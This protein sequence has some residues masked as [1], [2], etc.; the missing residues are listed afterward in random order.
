MSGDMLPAERVLNDLRKACDAAGSQVA[1]AE[2]NDVSPA[3]LSETLSK[4][5]DLSPA[6]LSALGYE[7]VVLYRKRK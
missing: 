5:R 3:L 2:A 7:R 4:R 6:V 1:W